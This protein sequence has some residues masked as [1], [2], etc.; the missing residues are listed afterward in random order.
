VAFE[1]EFCSLPGLSNQENKAVIPNRRT[2]AREESAV[3]L[4]LATNCRLPTI[5]RRRANKSPPAF[6]APANQST[7]TGSTH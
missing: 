2:A 7:A 5:N 6:P 3:H 1:F 4:I